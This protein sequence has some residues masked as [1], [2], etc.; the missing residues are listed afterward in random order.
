MYTNL[1]ETYSMRLNKLKLRNF[2]SYS[3][4]I[5]FSIDDLNVLIGRNDIGKSSILEALDIFFNGKPDKDDLT[6]GNGAN[7]IE[8][9]CVF[10]DLPETLTLDDTVETS[11]K[12]EYL[13]NSEQKL[14]IKKKFPVSGSGSVSEESVIVCNYP[15]HADLSDLLSKKRTTLKLQFEEL[16]INPEE[17]I[18]IEVKSLEMLLDSI[19]TLTDKLKPKEP[20]LKLMVS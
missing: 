20:K 15:I 16:G 5:E 10:D 6:V 1:K 4:E 18:G 19:I 2:R 7:Q 11:L 9:T 12:D 8:I 13:L 3:N 17:L 14:E